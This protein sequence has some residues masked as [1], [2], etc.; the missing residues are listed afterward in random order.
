MIY[1]INFINFRFFPE[2]SKFRINVDK[3]RIECQSIGESLFVLTNKCKNYFK[4]INIVRLECSS[5]DV[6]KNVT[7]S[8]K[9]IFFD[10]WETKLH[11]SKI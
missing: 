9:F 8:R 10:K 4:P 7:Y 5:R 11:C 1:P 2:F 6:V 3:T